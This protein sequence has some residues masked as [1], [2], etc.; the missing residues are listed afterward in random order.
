MSRRWKNCACLPAP[1]RTR[2]RRSRSSCAATTNGCPAWIWASTGPSFPGSASAFT[3]TGGRRKP[4][5]NTC[6]PA[7]PKS[8]STPVRSNRRPKPSS[9]RPRR[10]VP[11][12]SALCSSGR[13]K[14]LPSPV[15]GPSPP[16]MSKPASM[17]CLGSPASGR[18]PVNPP[19]ILA[20]FRHP[21]N[22]AI[23]TDRSSW[24]DLFAT[25]LRFYHDQPIRVYREALH[26]VNHIKKY[27]GTDTVNI[28]L[29]T[30]PDT[31]HA[32][33]MRQILEKLKVKQLVMHLPWNH[34]ADVKALL[35]DS[36]VTTNAIREK[37][38]RNLSAA[39]EIEQL[40]I[41][42]GIPISEPF[43]GVKTTDGVLTILGP[44]KEFYQEMLSGFKFMP[45]A[46]LK[47]PVSLLAEA[48]R[49]FGTTVAKWIAETW[50][51]E[52]L[53]EPAADAT[54]SENN[55]SVI[56]KLEVGGKNLLFTGDAGV[57]AIKSAISFAD[58]NGIALT[59]INFFDVPHH[60]SRRNFGPS[61][62][63]RLFGNIR[64]ND[65]K[66][67]TAFISAAKG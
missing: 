32:S 3:W 67:W 34:S 14:T 6:K 63:N 16:P 17:L 20:R 29:L 50:S 10:A 23:N 53:Q 25:F 24:T 11:A 33:G 39:R 27:Y 1:G 4:S 30:H 37:A 5:A 41:A 58:A 28:A 26:L 43:A 13:W 21:G 15:A 44:T 18:P 55:S 66:D 40:A 31:D 51:T 59:G 48:L 60:G 46:E 49:A 61:I 47:S 12:L 57:P 65:A 62:A 7:S 2:S 54:S 56:F 22:T 45:E 42:K 38:K 8:A 9:S 19:V 64:Q 35:D 36:R 52:T